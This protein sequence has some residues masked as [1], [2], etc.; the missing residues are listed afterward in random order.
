MSKVALALLAL[1]LFAA[2]AQAQVRAS[3]ETA[4]LFDDEAG[5]DADADDPAIWVHPAD[6]RGTLVLGTKKNA[7]LDVYDLRGRTL[8]SIPA[9]P[10]RFNNVD[11]LTGVKLNGKVR[12]LVVT[13]DRGL[14]KLRVFAIDPA[15]ALRGQAPLTDVTA[16]NAPLV[17]S[18]TPGEVQTQATAYGLAAYTDRQDG[19]VAVS[20]RSRTTVALYKLVAAPNHTV[21]YARVDAFTLPDT[22]RLPDGKAWS[23]CEDPGDGPQVEGMSFDPERGLLFAAQEDIGLWVVK[24][25][26]GGFAGA[27]QLLQKVK[28][29]GVP[30]TFDPE[31]EECVLG[32]D[33]GFGGKHVAADIEGLT[34][35][36]IP[37]VKDV[38][39]VSS[40]GDSRFVAYGDGGLGGFLGDFTITDG[41]VDGVEHSDGAQVLAEPLPGFPLGL[42]V[43]HDGENRPDPEERESTNFKYTR[44]ERVGVALL[45]QRF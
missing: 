10:G 32:A 19:F 16:V 38:L 33:P 36:R 25:G 5:G 41:G 13:S 12:D 34:I 37:F 42:L 24:A 9:A 21:S 40:Q 44:L 39:L 6:R 26:R 14:D 35:W 15:K 45:L 11:V 18:A 4:P 20:R 30:G 27:P 22:F 17:F 23:P 3:L 1:F 7:G 2:P 29:F 31:T 8:Q 28:E 43:T